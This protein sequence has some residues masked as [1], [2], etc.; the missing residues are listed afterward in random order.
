M[1]VSNLKCA[2]KHYMPFEHQICCE[3]GKAPFGPHPHH[4]HRLARWCSA[5]K[6]ATVRSR[7]TKPHGLRLF[8]I[9]LRDPCRPLVAATVFLSALRYARSKTPNS[10]F[11]WCGTR[12]N[13][14]AAKR[15]LVL[16]FYVKS[17]VFF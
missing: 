10:I 3:E 7:R 4:F 6:H 11:L 13:H 8:F 5:G 1:D 16:K 12:P 17:V 14:Q 9:S 15:H 2:R